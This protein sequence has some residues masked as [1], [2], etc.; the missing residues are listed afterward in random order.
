MGV[1]IRSRPG[2]SKNHNND[3]HHQDD[4]LNSVTEMN[5]NGF[6]SSS[7]STKDLEWTKP[8]FGLPIYIV[9]ERTPEF[10]WIFSILLCF[11]TKKG[12]ARKA[13]SFWRSQN[14]TR[15]M[16]MQGSYKKASFSAMV[17]FCCG[18]QEEFPLHMRFFFL[19]PCDCIYF[20]SCF[21]F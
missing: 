6:T 3:D 5:S 17:I 7:S 18:L 2:R 10:L 15:I 16:I 14:C 11:L 21:Q 20:S 19:F 8:S 1:N 12:C 4:M 9:Y 13:S